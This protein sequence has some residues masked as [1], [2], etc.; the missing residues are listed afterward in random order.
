MGTSNLSP[1]YRQKEKDGHSEWAQLSD[2][3]KYMFVK[4]SKRDILAL[5]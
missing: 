3:K 4:S 1:K 2:W 5:I